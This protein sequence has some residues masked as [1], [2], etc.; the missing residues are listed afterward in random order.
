MFYFSSQLMLLNSLGQTLCFLC[1]ARAEISVLF[2]LLWEA[3]LC[4][5]NLGIS[6]DLSRVYTQNLGAPL[7]QLTSFWEPK[8]R[9]KKQIPIYMDSWLAAKVQRLSGEKI[10]FSSNGAETIKYLYAK[11]KTKKTFGSYLTAYTKI[12]S[13][14]IID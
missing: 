10:T 14:W 1:W 8:Y 4:V 6:R 2:F 7:L 9:V 12:N 13:K 11:T 5:H 3:A